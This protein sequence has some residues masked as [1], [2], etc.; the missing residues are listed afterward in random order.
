MT[1][2]KEKLSDAEKEIQRLTQLYDAVSANSVMNPTVAMEMETV[3]SPFASVD[4]S[5]A[6]SNSTFT[7]YVGYEELHYLAE[8]N[9]ITAVE[10]MLSNTQR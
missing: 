7:G 10:W 9:F 1:K 4:S 5:F 8:Q 3:N 6:N 2:L